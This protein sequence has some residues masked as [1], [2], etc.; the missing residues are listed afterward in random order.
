LRKFCEKDRG[1]QVEDREICDWD[2]NTYREKF[3]DRE[4]MVGSAKKINKMPHGGVYMG[5]T[6]ES[7]STKY[8]PFI[9]RFTG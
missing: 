2:P 1:L 6:W 8:K 4:R 7:V 9:N 5:D 3:E